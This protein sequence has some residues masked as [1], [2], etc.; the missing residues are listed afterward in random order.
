LN[1]LLFESPG[2]R[3]LVALAIGLLTGV[4]RERRKGEGDT[5]APAGLRTFML[6]ALLGGLAAQTGSDLLVVLAGAFTAGAALVGYALGDHRDPGLTSEVALFVTYLLGVLAQSNPVLALEVS[7]VVTV[8]LAYRTQ[9]H[10]LARDVL[11]ER[12]LLDGLTLAMAA[13]V[14]WPLLPNRAIDPYGLINPF[15]LWRLAVV[16]MGLSALGYIGQRIFG[17]RYGL[18]VAG[19]TAGFISSTAAIVAMGERA[20]SD[21]RVAGPTAAGA[22]SSLLGS[23][24]Y[25]TALVAAANPGLFRLLAVP[26]GFAVAMTLGYA[27]ALNWRF[28][29]SS[30]VVAM[31]GRAFNMWTAMLFAALVAGFAA[32]STALTTWLGAAGALAG[33]GATGLVDAHAAAV[34]LATLSGAG[35]IDDAT[36]AL[37]ILMALSANMA[38]KA[39]TAFVCGP[40]PFA[41]RI[42]AGLMLLLAGIWTGYGLAVFF[43][44]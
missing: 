17:T 22:I 10:H 38:A 1:P 19:F 34:S 3:L 35:E 16:L 13:L 9:L 21:P 32:V 25:L 7:V 33:A 11:T 29:S 31:P 12:E 39:P 20:Q 37:G 23:L 15:I 14:V 24:M 18:T 44:S 8:L 5:R 4:E 42:T 43:H 41:F 2:W 36:A 40:R 6:V 28:S 30:D 27:I 26:L